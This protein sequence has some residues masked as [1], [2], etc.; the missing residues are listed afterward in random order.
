MQTNIYPQQWLHLSKEVRLH[1]MKVFGIIRTGI[2]EIRDQEVI[3]DGFTADDLK[4][5][6][7]E[8]MCEYIGSQ[9]TFLRAWE[10]T[11]A[12]IHAELNPPIGEIRNVNGEGTIIDIEED[13]RVELPAGEVTVEKSEMTFTPEKPWC[14][15]C[16]SKGV[17]HKLGC[18]KYTPTQ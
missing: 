3:S 18:P 4:A 14:D 17:R 2:T 16:T 6:T 15:T 10:V 1:L 13:I 7:L 11:L 5:I 8:K 12:K 9:E